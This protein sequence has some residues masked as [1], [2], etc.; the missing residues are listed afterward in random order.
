MRKKNILIVTEIAKKKLYF[1]RTIETIFWIVE[2]KISKKFVFNRQLIKIAFI[3]IFILKN[4]VISEKKT[5]NQ[6]FDQ[7]TNINSKN[8]KK[9]FQTINQKKNVWQLWHKRLKHVNLTRMK[10]LIDQMIDMKIDNFSKKNQLLCEI[11]NYFKLTKKIHCNSSKRAFRRLKK[12]HTNVW[13]SFRIFNFEK[14]R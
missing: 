13:N 11:C 1:L 14:N 6:Q 9:K 3:S 4:S 7:L 12:I 10:L 5:N 8:S 2:K